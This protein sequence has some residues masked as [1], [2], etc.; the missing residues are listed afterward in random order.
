MLG[1]RNTTSGMGRSMRVGQ[2]FPRWRCF[3]S[4]GSFARAATCAAIVLAMTSVFGP[5]ARSEVLDVDYM[6]CRN[7]ACAYVYQ[8]EGVDHPQLV[9]HIWRSGTSYMLATVYTF[10]Y[11]FPVD[12]SPSISMYIDNHLAHRTG[13]SPVSMTEQDVLQMTEDGWI[14]LQGIELAHNGPGTYHLGFWPT[15]SE[16]QSIVEEELDNIPQAILQ[17]DID[18]G[19][20]D[21]NFPADPNEP[22][23][24]PE[25]A[26]RDLVICEEFEDP[27]GRWVNCDP[28]ADPPDLASGGFAICEE[29]EDP[30]GRWVDCGS[31]TDRP[32]VPEHA[33]VK[34]VICHKTSLPGRY[35]DTLVCDSRSRK[36]LP[37]NLRRELAARNDCRGSRRLSSCPPHRELLLIEQT[38]P[39]FQAMVNRDLL[40]ARGMQLTTPN[41]ALSEQMCSSEDLEQ[42]PTVNACSRRCD[43]CNEMQFFIDSQNATLAC[44]AVT[45]VGVVVVGTNLEGAAVLSLSEIVAASARIGA[46]IVTTAFGLCT[47][48]YIASRAAFRSARLNQCKTYC[49]YVFEGGGTGGQ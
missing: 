19:N 36:Y 48:G 24:P 4:V 45:A 35:T 38:R 46:S 42:Q 31:T 18:N 17:W 20:I 9:A 40:N 37:V 43:T 47:G 41:T 33:R 39:L 8:G 10:I 21:P 32:I 3:N 15:E 28:P 30:Q 13:P 7:V 25:P 1:Q 34:P 6:G 29:F 44:L 49:E 22:V 11:D 16:F 23:A 27:Q 5:H 14:L 26:S 12:S 2:R